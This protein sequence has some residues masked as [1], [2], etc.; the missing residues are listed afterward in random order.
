MFICNRADFCSIRE[1]IRASLVE[2]WFVFLRDR[3]STQNTHGETKQALI[4]SRI[5]HKSARLH[6]Y[7]P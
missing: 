3:R 1:N 7:H 6:A 5:E 2:P 4:F